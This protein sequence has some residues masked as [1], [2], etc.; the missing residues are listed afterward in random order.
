MVVLALGQ[1]VPGQDGEL[2]SHSDEGHLAA[3][4][5]ADAE[6]EG[7]QRPGSADSGVGRLNEEA[8]SVCLALPADVAG[9]RGLVPGLPDTG[10][11]AEVADELVRPGEARDIPHDGDERG[12][13]GDAHAGDR[14]QPLDARVTKRCLGNQLV[15]SGDL[16]LHAVQLAECAIQ[17]LA[18]SGREVQVGKPLAAPLPEGVGPGTLQQVAME[19]GLH[20]VAQPGALLDQSG[21][22]R[23]LGAPGSGFWVGDPHLGEE[24]RGEQLRKR[25][26]V[27]LVRLHLGGRDGARAKR[28]RDDDLSSVGSQ[29]VDDG[30]C[31][32]GGLEH[33]LVL[34]PEAPREGK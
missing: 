33:H 19:D 8:T 15:R 24:V 22:M 13:G 28:I 18:I 2:P 23:D 20:S 16:R 29:N 34:L 25:G 12:S 30:P 7:A 31:V 32:D 26:G 10:I 3:A 21:P 1:K 14:H 4:A 27:D 5:G 9:V 17:L 6:V 11:E